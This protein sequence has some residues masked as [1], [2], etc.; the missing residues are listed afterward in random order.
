MK[1]LLDFLYKYAHVI[2]FLLLLSICLV[3]IILNNSFQQYV[4]LSSSNTVVGYISEKRHNVNSYLSLKSENQKLLE[5]NERLR[6]TLEYYRKDGIVEIESKQYEF[7]AANVVRATKNQTKNYLTINKGKADGVEQ[8]LGVISNE[9]IVG[10]TMI[11]GNNYTTVLPIINTLFRLSVKI[12]KNDYFGSLSWS[13]SNVNYA[14]LRDIPGYID[15]S[16]GDTIVTTGFSAF[17]PEGIPVGEIHAFIKDKA[18][19]FYEIDVKLFTDFNNIQYVYVIH[20]F[21][22]KEQLKVESE[23][24]DN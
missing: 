24:N 1:N 15:I 21:E 12:K 20:N 13:G 22:K 5:E 19:G 23:L 18:S 2:F 7:I 16:V 10:I 14:S 4:F 9:G 11:S 8:D 3:L 6:N 17:F